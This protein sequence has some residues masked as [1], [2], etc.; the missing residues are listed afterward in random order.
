MATMNNLTS[1]QLTPAEQVEALAFFKVLK[2]NDFSAATAMLSTRAIAFVLGVQP[3]TIRKHC[4]LGTIP[5]IRV[6]NRFR[7]S[8]ANVAALAKRGLPAVRG[9]D[10]VAEPE[11]VE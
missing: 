3:A 9:L 8:A 11:G 10:R 1:K 7:V 2:H 6:G 4:A 5:A